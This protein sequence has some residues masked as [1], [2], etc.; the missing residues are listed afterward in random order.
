MRD[1][2]HRIAELLSGLLRGDEV[3]LASFSGEESDF[4]RLNGN[5]VRQAGSVAQRSL[6][7]EW[8]R[9]RRHAHASLA[10]AGDLELDRARLAAEVANLRDVLEQVADDPFLLYSTEL[11]SS[12]RPGEHRL[13]EAAAALDGI[14]KTC[15]GRDAVG[16]YAAGGSFSGFAN[17]LG[18][19]NWHES[20]SYNFD[21]SF[22]HSGD[23]A[24]KASYAGFD[25][26]LAELER[27]VGFAAEQ[28]AALGRSSRTIEPGRYRVYLAPAALD[29]IFGM[30]SWGGFGLRAHRT[31]TTPLLRMIQQGATLHPSISVGENTRDGTAPDF[32][33]EGFIRP[34][35]VDLIRGGRYADALVSP[36][37]AVEYEV[38][39][40]GAS[41]REAPVALD[42]APGDLSR[43]AVLRELGTGIY[44]SNLHYL[45]YS[46]RN[47]CRTTGMTR[48]A[49]FWVEDGVIRSPLDVMRFD[50]TVYRMLGENLVGLTH[51]REMIL[52]PMTYGRRSSRS[53]RL[54]G[55]LIDD[56]TFTL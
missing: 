7:L 53:A 52:D 25:W 17:S 23:K 44:V 43:D 24:V 10:L 21:W 19:R 20:Y 18:Q 30:L 38:A 8:I 16:L 49:T 4:V 32:Q 31:R 29:D 33:G 3:Y 50:E 37:S 39:T 54:P 22:Y 51:E 47:A 42:V 15:E 1:Y 45:N 28:L 14:R 5:R 27:R 48:F 11:H 56:F 2:F 46:D 9:G 41:A 6:G 26:S 55:A 36:R 35:R 13:P 34:P 12:E 40:N